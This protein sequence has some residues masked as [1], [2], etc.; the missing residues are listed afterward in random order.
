M[1]TSNVPS[2]ATPEA[3]KVVT[4]LFSDV[5]ESTR[6]GGELDP[7]TV[8]E[9]MSRYFAIVRPILERHGGVVEKFIGDAVMAVF[10]VPQAH[11]DDALRAVRAAAEL[12]DGLGRLNE[13]LAQT[14]G[15]TVKTRIGVNTGEVIAGDPTQGH[16]FVAG[17]A[18][19]VAARLEQAATPGEILVGETTYR[20]VQAAVV[21]DDPGPLTVKGKPE[22]IRAMR[23]V[24]VIPEAS[25]WSRRLDSP[26]V[27]R[28][29]EL[30]ALDSAFA[31]A[32]ES[33][34]A[35][36]ATVMGPAGAGKSRLTHEFASRL[37]GNA[38]VISG[39]CL[40]YGEGITFWPIATVLRDAA[41][42]GERDSRDSA[43][44]KIAALLEGNADATQVA[45]RLAPLLG[46]GST[47]PGLQ[48]TFWAVRKLF[49]HL[50]ARRPLVVAFDDLQ[51]GEATFLD[52]I[53]Y[54]V[55]RLR[56]APVLLL[57]LARPELLETRPAWTARPGGLLVQLQPL[58]DDEI[59]ALIRNLVGGAELAD[60]ARARIA[61][62]AEGNPLFVEEVLRMLVDEGL[63]RQNGKWEATG[64]LSRLAIP[65]TIHALVTARLD[66]LEPEEKAVIERA[67]V[68]GRVFWW[69][70]LSELSPTELR[71]KIIRHLQSLTRKE[72]IEPDYAETDRDSAFRFAHIVVRDAAYQGIPKT[73]RAELHERL[74]DFIEGES[75]ELAGDYYELLG[76]HLEQSAR[77]RLELGRGGEETQ[78]L[79]GRAAAFLANAGRRAFAWGDMPSAVKL[80]GRAAALL[81]KHG[82]DRA[83]LLTQLAFAL[84]ET[85][86]LASLQEVVEETTATAAA[87]GDSSLAAYATILGLWISLSWETEGW[88]D[89]AE[90]EATKA[91]D[92]FR[93]A[94]DDR[95][96]AKAWALLGLVHLERAQFA[97]AEEAYEKAA[98]HAHAVGDRRDELE[99][100][101]WIPL[102]VW[103]GP[104]HTEAGLARCA[105]VRER[106]EGDAKVTASTLIAEAAFA[107]GLGRFGEARAL[108][109]RAKALLEEVAL[110]QWVA[111]PVAQLAG[112]IELLAGNSAGAET[113]LRHGYDTL[114]AIGEVS[115][116]S[117]LAA[118]LA[119]AVSSQGRDD[120]ADEL[121]RV[122]EESAGAADI[123]SHAQLRAVRAKVR[124]RAGESESADRLSSEA[125]A[126]ADTT[127]FLHLRWHTRVSR[128]ETL[129]ALGRADDSRTILEEAIAIA[130]LKG[131]P[132]AANRARALLGGTAPG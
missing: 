79:S 57:C 92:A 20:L 63:L 87:S 61:E 48:E 11:E 119:E 129:A 99:S 59:D 91:L 25:G 28:E 113:E 89:V 44:R 72:L 3:R 84:F 77:L 41:E 6:L 100:L 33:G 105:E 117:S 38:V 55:E 51:W 56:T 40:P 69:D 75:G 96:L 29:R 118:I 86:D 127:D 107:G 94:R 132:V 32:V 24:D 88:A 54:L 52:L 23:L 21:A 110:T 66:R 76:Y 17:D 125:V 126:L 15:V 128:A 42:I 13:E 39:R 64:D 112:W 70:A 120:E 71:P 5:V 47:A 26:L 30:V 7:E 103:A 123:Y 81:P 60:A 95:G 98:R 115:W 43:A 90:A 18:V 62:V 131:S 58:T 74:A 27:G 10:G 4:V 16:S 2:A 46:L 67:S 104:V 68:V 130:D 50:A 78:A 93:R 22:P 19:N 45:G 31:R 102:A 14:W 116:L 73:E 53:E 9:L 97:A 37:G 122:S 34:A 114:R 36:V 82:R 121:T 109:T 12:R 1:S 80:L 111:G 85:G 106:A 83:E 108:V 35:G 8:R 124:A 65:P 101:S 49:E